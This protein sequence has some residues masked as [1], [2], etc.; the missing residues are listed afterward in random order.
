MVET[1]SVGSVDNLEEVVESTCM[2]NVGSTI[3]CFVV[4]DSHPRLEDGLQVVETRKHEFAKVDF[5]L[6]KSPLVDYIH[7]ERFVEF[8]PIKIR[9]RI[10][11]KKGRMK[12]VKC[13]IGNTSKL[14]FLVSL[15]NIWVWFIMQVRTKAFFLTCVMIMGNMV[16]NLTET[17]TWH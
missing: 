8:N 10:F 1:P 9:G 5:V 12:L 11:S 17:S 4:V 7:V 6:E 2:E 16:S 14:I 3:E 15:F 13:C